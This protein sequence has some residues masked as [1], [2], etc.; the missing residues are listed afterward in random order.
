MEQILKK[1]VVEDTKV[2]NDLNRDKSG[3]IGWS[4]TVRLKKLTGLKIVK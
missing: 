4:T 1:T 2:V 3:Q